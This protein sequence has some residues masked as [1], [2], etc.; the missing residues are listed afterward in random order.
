MTGAAPDDILWGVTVLNTLETLE[1][2]YDAVPRP[3][4]TTEEL[5]PF[6]LF[7]RRDPDGWPYYARPRLGYDGPVPSASVDDVRARQREL[8]VPEAF[9][10]VHETT[11]GLLAAAREAGLAECPLLVLPAE[12]VPV[13]P[14][15]PDSFRVVPLAADAREVGDVVTAVSAGFA[16]T[17]DVAPG[18]AGRFPRLIAEG[19]VAM[20]GAYDGETAIGGGTHG[21][22]GTTTELTG[23]A[24]IP[25]A[26]RTGVGAAI[27]VALVAD[28]RNRGV[29]TVFLSAWTDAVARVYERVGFVRVGTACI[30]GRAGGTEP[31]DG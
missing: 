7:L 23:I 25:R 5:G 8:G 31:A 24:V 21:P 9:E 6:T 13:R 2:Y 11:P 16:G 14:S 1:T 30:A 26:R 18:D 12:A 19:L 20:A 17:D 10:W 29:E 27:T 4:A 22:R 3:L 28:A 15:L